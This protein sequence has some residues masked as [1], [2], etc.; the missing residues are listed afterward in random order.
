VFALSSF[1]VAAIRRPTDSA[2]LIRGLLLL[3]AAACSRTDSRETQGGVQ[4][5]SSPATQAT[6]RG[7]D[8]LVLRVPVTGGGSRV[9]AYGNLDSTIWAGDAPLPALDRILAFDDNDGIIAFVDKRGR[10]GRLDLNLGTVSIASRERLSSLT[11]VNAAAIYGIDARGVVQRYTPSGDWSFTPHRPA[12]EVF[13]LIDGSILVLGGRNPTV[14][15]WRVRPPNTDILESLTVNDV[16]TTLRTS[17]GDRIYFSDGSELLPVDTRT[18]QARPA[19]G[20]VGSVMALAATPSGDRVFVVPDSGS[21]LRVIDRYRGRVAAKLALP[22]RPRDLRVDPLGRLLLVRDAVHDSVWVVAV[23]NDRILG[24]V[25]SRWRGDLPFVGPDGAILTL[26]GNDVIVRD[27][28]TLRPVQRVAEGG[29]DFWFSFWWTGFRLHPIPSDSVVIALP[30]T[31][32][33]VATVSR[34]PDSVA[35]VSA[36]AVDTVVPP[37]PGFV[38]QFKAS[39]SEQLARDFAATIKVGT[40]TPRIETSMIA[41]IP[42]YRVVLGPYPTRE[43]AERIGRASGLSFCIFDGV[44]CQ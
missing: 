16:R 3:A 29:N 20:G 26:E 38:L 15:L 21:E 27:P 7:P 44:K 23:G 28:R 42:V 33:T 37:P 6:V 30:D 5:P 4:A 22:R 17:V 19:I 11:S 8:R 32:D 36:A 34:P 1:F 12:R 35:T 9:V 25:P 18:L 24:A 14:T 2:A 40:E 41:G 43:E 13:P 10:P 39:G 31:V